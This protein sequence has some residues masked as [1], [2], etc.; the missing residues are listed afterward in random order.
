MA[1]RPTAAVGGGGSRGGGAGPRVVGDYIFGKLIGRGSFSDVWLARHRVRGTE[2]AVKEIAMERLS[3]KLQE[4]L[5]S[6][7]VILKKI[8]HPNIIA[9]LDIIEYPKT[10]YIILEFCRGGDLSLYIQRHGRVPEATAK[11]F[12]QQ[13]AVGLQVLRE[14]NLIHRDLKPQNLLLSSTDDNSTLK[15]ADFGFARPLQPRGLAE[16][17]CGSPLYMAPEIMQ[18]Q[19]YDAKA[20]LWSV[21]V[22]LFQLLTG[23]TPFTGNSQIE[24]FCV[25][26][27]SNFNFS[28]VILLNR[29]MYYSVYSYGKCNLSK[30]SHTCLLL[31][32]LL[33]NIM[34]SNELHFPPNNNDL[35]HE[36]IDL[37]QKLL[38]RN[39]G[40]KDDVLKLPKQF[41]LAVSS[42][43]WCLLVDHHLGSEVQI[44]N[45]GAKVQRM[46][47]SNYLKQ[48]D[49]AD[50]SLPWCLLVDHLG[51]ERLTFDEFFNHQ[52]LSEN[53][54]DEPLG[55][56]CTLS[57]VGD[58]FSSV[59]CAQVRAPEGSFQDDCLP[60]L[61]D[62]EIT[63]LEGNSS[64]LIRNSSMQC[65]SS[66]QEGSEPV[67]TRNSS[68]RST[69]G[70]TVRSN[71]DKMPSCSP[72]KNT[73]ALSRYSLH[74]PGNTTGRTNFNTPSRGDVK[75]IKPPM[76]GSPVRFL[77][78]DPM[79]TD[80]LELID[81]DYVLVSGPPME[82]SSSSVSAS[83][84]C[85]SP[86]NS[87]VAQI[88]SKG[89]CPFSA[90]IKITGAAVSKTC[91]TG[92]LESRSSLPSVASQGSVD[93]IDAMEQPSTHCLTRITSLQKCASA[94]SELVNEKNHAV[95]TEDLNS[96]HV[97]ISAGGYCFDHRV[98]VPKILA[99]KLL[100]AFSIQLVVLAIW[101]QALHICH[102]QAA[103]A[104]EGSPSQEIRDMGSMNK[105][106]A[107]C[108]EDLSSTQPLEPHDVSSD[109]EQAFLLE[110]G[111]ADEL[112]RD[113]GPVDETTEMPDAMEMVFQAALALGRAGAVDELMENMDNATASYSKAVRLLNFL[114]VEAP[115]LILNPPFSLTNS[116]RFRLRQY[117]DILSNRQNQSRSTRMNLLKCEEQR[118][119]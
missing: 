35:S 28:H 99:G 15:I 52:F 108:S 23:K 105:K 59:E 89:E 54:P 39:P 107:S 46:M 76:D 93:M 62:D 53:L 27:F 81:Q 112:A 43:P 82:A 14:H 49:L 20:D 34:R 41:E 6:E 80:S 18:L 87:E 1:Q 77:S 70:F 90:P 84:T 65:T 60:F 31:I 96:V 91:V 114:L 33:Q 69:Y 4:S 3:R 103:S 116:D 16:T 55:N 85:N 37:C 74:R 73:D 22:I 78:K 106:D 50:S 104:I 56:S 119:L 25:F 36:C 71:V 83:R 13:L 72:S 57:H 17:L 30:F 75:E 98:P 101:K 47:F 29:E 21:G 109:I 9:L 88:A 48:I 44:H 79:T 61:L 110:V 68:M 117:I 102:A 67:A 42:L 86:C 51:M 95:F 38:R 32:Q 58:D 118:S 94:I 97:A 26:Y 113:L 66:R 115:S 100:E 7:I 40:P 8:N 92:S 45:P 5:L 19:K 2:V 10:I 64:R 63:G 12:M 24:V 111:H 11:Y